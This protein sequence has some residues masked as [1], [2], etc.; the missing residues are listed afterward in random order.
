[1]PYHTLWVD[2][3]SGPVTESVRLHQR[4]VPFADV[5]R[6]D[7]GADGVRQYRQVKL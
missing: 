1:M 4:M 2:D 7:Y 5:L 6:R 3:H